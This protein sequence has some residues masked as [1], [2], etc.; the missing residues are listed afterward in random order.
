MDLTTLAFLLFVPVTIVNLFAVFFVRHY[1]H[2]DEVYFQQLRE[3]AKELKDVISDARKSLKAVGKEQ[4][5]KAS[6]KQVELKLTE[7]TA[8][9]L[10][11]KNKAIK[12]KR[13]G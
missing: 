11:L 1:G 8:E 5:V 12:V 13:H 9:L 7:A 2:K 10:Y 4:D 6:I 3:R